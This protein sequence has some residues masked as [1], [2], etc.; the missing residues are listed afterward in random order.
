VQRQHLA[1]GTAAGHTDDGEAFYTL[2]DVARLLGLPRRD[3]AALVEEGALA[4]RTT[5][6]GIVVTDSEVE[7]H[8]ALAAH[9]VSASDVAAHD[10]LSVQ[11]AA[12]LLH[13]TPRYVRRVCA[14]FINDTGHDKTALACQV[15]PADQR[16][17]YRIRRDD[18]AAF[19]GTREPPVARIG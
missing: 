7:R 2:P 19:A 12:R 11:D 15:D 18:L 4:T 13:V 6:A 5:P 3:I 8:L 14:N 16:G 1:V 10:M 17:S 9:P